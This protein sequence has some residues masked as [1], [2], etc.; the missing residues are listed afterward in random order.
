MWEWEDWYVLRVHKCILWVILVS[1]MLFWRHKLSWL[2]WLLT[3]FYH[4]TY[5]DPSAGLELNITPVISPVKTDFFPD[6]IPFWN[7][8]HTT[9]AAFSKTGFCQLSSNNYY[10]IASHLHI[11][12]L[13][14]NKICWM[15]FSY[16]TTL[17]CIDHG[18]IYFICV[19]QWPKVDKIFF[20][21]LWRT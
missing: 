12:M 7:N 20:L 17:I 16:V 19:Y 11:F 14:Q 5:S 3:T 10:Q 2:V 4:A 9:V 1:F 8:K 6:G 21:P 15:L 18:N 13:I